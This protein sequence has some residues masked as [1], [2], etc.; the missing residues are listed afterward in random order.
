[1]HVLVFVNYWIEKCTV[2]HWNYPVTVI[3]QHRNVGSV[4]GKH[5]NSTALVWLTK[6]TSGCWHLCIVMSYKHFYFCRFLEHTVYKNNLHTWGELNKILKHALQKAQHI[7][8][9]KVT[10]IL[11]L[12]L[13]NFM[14]SPCVFKSVAFIFQKMHLIV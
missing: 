14:F 12:A 4:V 8:M 5:L 1:M 11:T 10:V 13:I 6:W 3:H 9:P 7:N 2:K